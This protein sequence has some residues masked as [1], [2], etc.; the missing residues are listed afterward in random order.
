MSNQPKSKRQ[1]L[2]DRR[3]SEERRSK[4]TG[5]GA[6]ALLVVGVIAVVVAF[7]LPSLRGVDTSNIIRAEEKPAPQANFNMLGDANAPVKVVEF[8]DYLCSH[9]Q[10][11][12][13]NQ[14]LTIIKNYVETGRIT[15]EY[16]PLALQVPNMTR[17]VE[18]T[19][20]AGDQ[21][22]FWP[23]KDLV[24]AN[25][26]ENTNALGDDYLTGYAEVLELDMGQFNECLSSGKYREKQQE[27][28]AKA[29]EAEIPGTPTFLVNGTQASRLELVS[30]I[31]AELA[32]AGK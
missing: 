29:R 5:Y 20:C 7:V 13:I 32:K 2:R 22:A 19:Y 11:Y 9:C 17:P 14:E 27:N 28:L 25:V 12:A 1:E 4:L 15:Y 30:V 21:N 8:A 23:Y 10:D 3:R 26:V 6:L 16:L 18:A 31:E 24:Y